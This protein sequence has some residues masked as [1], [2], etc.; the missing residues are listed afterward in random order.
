MDDDDIRYVWEPGSSSGPYCRKVL[1]FT[2]SS[3]TFDGYFYDSQ[4]S[5]PQQRL[6]SVYATDYVEGDTTH[7]KRLAYYHIEITE[8]IEGED[9]SVY[10]PSDPNDPDDDEFGGGGI[11]FFPTHHITLKFRILHK[12]FDKETEAKI[13][14]AWPKEKR[15]TFCI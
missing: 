3:I 9:T 7:L 14:V 2:E 4:E 13:L 12:D 1:E 11:C 8:K 15:A 5:L 10:S 6:L